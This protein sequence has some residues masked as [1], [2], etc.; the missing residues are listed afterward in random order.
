[1]GLG[2]CTGSMAMCS[3]GAAPAPMTFLPTSMIMMSG[4]PGGCIADCVPFLNIAPFG[5]CMSLLN[6]ITLAQT[7]AAFGVLTPGA[8]IPVPA[9]TWIPVKPNVLGKCGPLITSDSM[10]MCA[11]AGVIKASVPAQFTVMI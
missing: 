7:T 4:C 10:L 1:M 8:C 3:F 6:P 11:Y 9:G 2:I 5:V